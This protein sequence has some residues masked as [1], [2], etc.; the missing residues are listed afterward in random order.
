MKCFVRS[1][2]AMQILSIIVYKWIVL[3]YAFQQ[4]PQIFHQMYTQQ[5]A[6]PNYL[7]G[8]PAYSV[9]FKQL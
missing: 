2:S 8:A 5:G 1:E 3:F 4:H 7:I 9:Y 6:H